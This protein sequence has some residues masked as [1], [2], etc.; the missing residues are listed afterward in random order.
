MTKKM[1]KKEMFTMVLAVVE[2]T[3]EIENKEE[4]ITFLNKELELLNKK[5]ST[6]NTKKKEENEILFAQ[7]KEALAEM[8]KPVTITEFMKQSTH[9]IASLSNQKLS[10]IFNQLAHKGEVVKTVEKKVSRF[11]LAEK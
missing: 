7:A 6:A 2:A 1:T 8:T 3:E 5:S 9:T 4:M 10:F 11:A